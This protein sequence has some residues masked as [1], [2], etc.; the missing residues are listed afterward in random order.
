MIMKKPNLYYA[1]NVTLQK[2]LEDAFCQI[3]EG[4][5]FEYIV[6]EINGGKLKIVFEPKGFHE[7]VV[8]DGVNGFGY[9]LVAELKK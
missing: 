2:V 5:G 8:I 7:Q 3:E 4:E 9:T 1:P 6:G